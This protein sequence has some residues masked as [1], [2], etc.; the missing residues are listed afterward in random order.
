MNIRNE[1]ASQLHLVGSAM[2]DIGLAIRVLCQCKFLEPINLP[3]IAASEVL[4]LKTELMVERDQ[5]RG[6]F[7][8]RIVL[9]RVHLKTPSKES[10]L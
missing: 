7:D 2:G 8:G 1:G 6:C 10:A 4:G 9:N 5:G 3:S